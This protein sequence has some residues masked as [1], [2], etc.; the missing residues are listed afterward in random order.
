MSERQASPF[1]PRTALAL[2]VFGA[3]VFLALLWMIGSNLGEGRSGLNN[4][5][6]HAASKGLTGYA[7]LSQYLQKRGFDVQLMRSRKM[8]Q[9]SGLLVLTPPAGADGKEIARIVEEHRP[10]GPTLVITPKWIG[11]RPPIP[12]KEAKQG[13]V[14]VAG[15]MPPDWPGF[16]D[17]IAVSLREEDAGASSARWS[18]SAGQG[19]LPDPGA[20]MTGSGKGLVPLVTL[21]G[22]AKVLAGYIADG[23]YYE[24][25]QDA[26]LE[27]EPEIDNETAD[28]HAD[29]YPLVLVFE[30]DLFNNFG[31]TRQGN[32]Q[33]AERLIRAAL[34]GGEGKVLFDLTLNGLGYSSNLLTLAL[35]PPYLAATLCLLL[36]ALIAIWRAFNRFGPPRLTGRALAFGKLALV[37]NAAA[38]IRR[39]GRL[40]L[41]TGPYADAARERL[42]R[43]LA[44]PSRLAPEAAEAA[45]DR[46]LA[47]RAAALPSFSSTAAALRDAR[48]PADILRAAQSLHSL[49]RI[50]TK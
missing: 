38:L 44:L 18:S 12:V 3:A 24:G 30:P 40:H 22:D 19:V 41:I 6:A 5:E 39:T 9:Q 42:M 31:F 43:A 2:V 10:F 35:Q 20:V 11:M 26:A 32:P 16:Q 14:L 29:H 36:A 25:L 28:A 7:A 46:A 8:A 27:D 15:T 17:Q 37:S 33:E 4:G 50:L 21:D 34:D 48:R 47:G 45:I 13:W 49:E 23:G 1:S